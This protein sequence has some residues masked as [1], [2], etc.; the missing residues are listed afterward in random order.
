MKA[1]MTLFL[2][3][4]MLA[5][6]T[7]VPVQAGD[8]EAGRKIAN[9]CRTCHGIDGYATIPIAPHIGGEPVEY[10]E[11]QLMAFKT[12]QRQHEMMSVVTAGLTAQQISDVAAW[13]AAHEARATLPEG[14]LAANAPQ[15]CVSCHGADGISQLLDAPNLAGETNI[16][17]D[18]QLKAFKRGKRQHDIM[19]DVAA[20][21][22]DAEIREIADWYAAVGLEILPA[23][24]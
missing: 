15:A 2:G 12:G 3:G 20:E 9:M 19:S 14:I 17:I 16:Y 22:S 13:Y 11:S 5:G 10:L 18:T 24:E 1:L 21:L 8:P 4:L 7:A 6:G 23:P